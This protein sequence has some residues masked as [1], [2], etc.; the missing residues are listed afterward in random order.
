VSYRGELC[1]DLSCYLQQE[2]V[3]FHEAGMPEWSHRF[4]RDAELLRMRA[5]REDDMEQAAIDASRRDLA[6]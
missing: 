5:D 3:R 1:R 2:A 6:A 4:E